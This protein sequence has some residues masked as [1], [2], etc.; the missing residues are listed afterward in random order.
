MNGTHAAAELQKLA[1]CLA[2]EPAELGM[3]ADVASGDL[4]ALRKQIDNALFEADKH[5][6]ARIASLSKV[7]P[8]AVAAKMTEFALPPLLAAR[9]AE[10]I[11]PAKAGEMVKRLSVDYLADVS[12]RLDASRAPEV[13]AKIPPETVGTVARVLARRQEWVVIGGFVAVVTPDALRASVAQFTGE[14][15]LHIGFVL[16]DSSRMDEVTDLL[17]EAQVQEMLAAAYDR[18]MWAELDEVLSYL[19]PPQ[20]KRIAALFAR[21]PDAARAAA[22]A[23]LADGR[24]GAASYAKLTGSG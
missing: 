11:E 22:D 9:S 23:A 16:E 14:Q 6:F 13:I 21:T 20:A 4:R 3:L 10:L 1:H 15:L 19:G 8:V 17:T 7:V 18:G 24:F 5:L 2:V 12:A